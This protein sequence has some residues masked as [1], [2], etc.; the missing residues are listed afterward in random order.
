[1]P[2][3]SEA[4]ELENRYIGSSGEPSLGDAFK[5][6]RSE[7]EKGN[8]DREL[9]LHLLFLCWYGLAEPAFLTGFLGSEFDDVHEFFN[10]V[11]EYVQPEIENDPEMLY[12]LGLGAHLF[13]L[14]LPGG[15]GVWD[16]RSEEYRRLYRHLCPQGI[17]P[18][19][20]LNRGY[21]GEYYFDQASV[22]GGY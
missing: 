14:M 6:L 22:E 21:Y 2:I 7:W 16:R 12:T 15:H 3:P 13:G 5:I 20:F 17:D 10:D 9:C 19:I 8:R 1:M 11:F 18:T 4:L